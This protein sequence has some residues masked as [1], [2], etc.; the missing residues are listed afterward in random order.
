M[1]PQ[2]IRRLRTESGY[3][4]TWLANQLKVSQGAISNWE[5]GKSV[6][7]PEQVSKLQDILGPTGS[8]R[9]PDLAV[10]PYGQWLTATREKAAVS[11]ADL[12][13]KAGISLAQIYNIETGRTT[14]P[15]MST[16]TKIETAL[17]AKPPPAV[18]KATAAE[19]EIPG[20]G[21]LMDFDPHDESDYPPDPGVYVFYDVSERPIYV[22]QSKNI[23]KRIREGHTDKFWYRTPIV[24]KA[25]Y[26]RVEDAALRKQL[27]S[28]LI[29][30]M[31]SNAVINKNM[32]D[33]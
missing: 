28:T 11:R 23:K 9:G 8:L 26:V 10:D 18:V 17:S 6:P 13:K 32:V 19:A 25:S 16:R 1:D 29:K 7:S 33:R 27:E 14:N 5:S 15:R 22:G 3:S 4:Q 30:F 31:K 21:Q 2:Q 24:S 12:A 20:L